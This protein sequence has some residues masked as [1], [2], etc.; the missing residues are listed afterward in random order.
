MFQ[1]VTG[2][3]LLGAEGALANVASVGSFLGVARLMHE[4]VRLDNKLFAACLAHKRTRKA[5]C[6]TVFAHIVL[7]PKRL[8]ANVAR[9]LL[10]TSVRN[11][12]PHEMFLAAERFS[13]VTTSKWALTCGRNKQWSS[14]GHTL[15]W[16]LRE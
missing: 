4:I 14:L 16:V 6:F 2:E 7:S 13:T 11:W 8:T 15:W 9:V 12:V 1:P 3:V 5:V 10:L